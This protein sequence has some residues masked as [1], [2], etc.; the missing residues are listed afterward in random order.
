MKHLTLAQRYQIQAYLKAGKSID[1]IAL[2]LGADRS[3]IYRE[4]KRNSKQRGQY[5]AAH[6]QM[7]CQ[8]RKERLKRPRRFDRTKED[9]IRK[10]IQQEQWSPEQIVGYCREQGIEMVSTERI[11]QYIR[12]D[13]AQGGKLYHHLRHRLKHRKRPV[14]GKHT[15]IKD[16]VSIDERPQIINNKER[17]GDWEI[18]TVIGKDG[19][20]AI[21][22]I[23]ERT[24]AFLMMS[25][26]SKGK[27]AAGLADKVNSMLLP[28][29]HQIYSITADNGSEFAEHVK[30]SKTLGIEFFFAHPYSSW[31]RGLN[32]NTN[33]LIRQYVP[34][35]TELNQYSDAE[36]AEIQYKI[37]RRPRK[38]LG[39]KTPKSL[40]FNFVDQNVAFVS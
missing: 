18:D 33:K 14:G 32:E 16:R 31:A 26:L 7:L 10:Y 38:K 12:A 13:K 1:F 11:Y 40:F 22:T 21:V 28:Y 30:I 3:S 17:F 39:F 9:F 23:V 25:K 35:S 19:K 15:I 36:L 24:T 5:N 34:K 8:E 37:N 27:N 2:E 4:L 6:A 20:G 29:K